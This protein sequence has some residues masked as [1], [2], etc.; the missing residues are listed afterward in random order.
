[1]ALEPLWASQQPPTYLKLKPGVLPGLLVCFF[2]VLGIF[3]IGFIFVP[4]AVVCTLVAI[5]ISIS[6]LSLSGMGVSLLAMVMTGIGLVTSSVL[7]TVLLGGFAYMY[8]MI[9]I[10]P[11]YEA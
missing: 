1:M 10:I 9:K 4:I 6:H 2:A 3:T 7:I 5:V 11:L 8:D